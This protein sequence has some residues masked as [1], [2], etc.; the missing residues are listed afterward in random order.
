MRNR[1][2]GLKSINLC[3]VWNSR[4]PTLCMDLGSSNQIV[5][6]FGSY[7]F[8]PDRFGVFQDFLSKSCLH[9]R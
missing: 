6:F 7:Y 3:G 9:K 1:F 8:L 4:S 2:V 5:T